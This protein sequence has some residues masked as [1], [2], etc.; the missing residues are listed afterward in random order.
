MKK[1]TVSILMTIFNHQNYLNESIKSLIN[2]NYK[3]WELIAIDNGST[4]GSGKILKNIKDKR[5]KKKFLKKNIGRTKC[6]NLGLKN[7]KGKFI[8]ILDSDDVAQNNRIKSQ[9][10][11][12]NSDNELWLVA[13]DF[14][15]ID[16]S[17]KIIS[18]P[19]EKFDLKK[20]L[21]DKPRMFLL[22]NFLAHSS[23]MYKSK[24]I[25]EIGGYPN[26]YLY[27]QDHAFYMKVFKN[28]KIKILRK[29]LVNI[30]VPHKKSETARIFNSKRIVSEQIRI[31][32][33]NLSN[34]QTSLFE[35]ILIL[36]NLLLKIIKFFIPNILM[37][38]KLKIIN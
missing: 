11:E 9:L 31:L 25:K 38:T 6:L 2:Q 12:F 1:P 22:K 15:L 17:S 30:R 29:K 32:L 5:I 8:A 35:K 7:C 23:V 34:F 19:K 33:W 21:Q 27:A 26:N 36:F 24:L 4:D 3:N 18:Y 28:Y 10:K 16:Q 37:K 20:N 13:S 14:N